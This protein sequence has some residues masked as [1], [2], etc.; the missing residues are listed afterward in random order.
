M[1]T[2][3][4]NG[5][6]Q[7]EQLQDELRRVQEQADFTERLLTERTDVPP[8]DAAAEEQRD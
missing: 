8:A 6:E 5:A 4:A 2:A 3:F 7:I 1:T